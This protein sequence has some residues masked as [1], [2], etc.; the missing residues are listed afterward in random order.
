MATCLA[1][2]SRILN[3]S[4]SQRMMS[5]EEAAALIDSGTRICMSGFTGSGYPKAV[6]LALARRI[7]DANLRG[8]KFQVTFVRCC[9]IICSAPSGCPLASTRLTCLA[10]A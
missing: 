10:K 8:Q 4:L 7:A 1:S 3:P 5:A 2:T 9:A 6:P